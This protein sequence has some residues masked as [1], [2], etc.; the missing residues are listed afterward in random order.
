M[1]NTFI[2][3]SAHQKPACRFLYIYRT[4]LPVSGSVTRL[5]M[6]PG[7][8]SVLKHRA[9]CRSGS[10]IMKCGSPSTAIDIRLATADNNLGCKILEFFHNLK[11]FN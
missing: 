10:S 9:S 7:R 8:S 5:K 1:G 4:Y 2:Y 11:Q 3:I 6:V